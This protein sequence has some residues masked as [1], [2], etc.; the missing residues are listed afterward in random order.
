MSVGSTKRCEH[1][2]SGFS[3]NK[4]VFDEAVCVRLT[5]CFIISIALGFT[6]SHRYLDGIHWM[7]STGIKSIVSKVSLQLTI[8][9]ASFTISSLNLHPTHRTNI[10]TLN[11][12][13][14]KR[15]Y[16]VWYL[17]TSVR[18][19]VYALEEERHET[20][21]GIS[22]FQRAAQLAERPK[23]PNVFG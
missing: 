9:M 1:V 7:V 3:L 17:L 23:H 15:L 18:H 12:F 19:I 4:R 16:I 21:F 5:S 6:E 22:K 20:I 10:Y 8:L 14:V 11:G 2:D 13:K